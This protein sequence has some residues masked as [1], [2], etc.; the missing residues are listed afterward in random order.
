[1]TEMENNDVIYSYDDKLLIDNSG[2]KQTSYLMMSNVVNSLLAKQGLQKVRIATGYWDLNGWNLTINQIEKFLEN[3]ND[4]ECFQLLI[5]KDPMIYLNQ[6]QNEPGKIIKNYPKNEIKLDLEKLE[7]NEEYQRG[8]AV[9]LKYLKLGR[10]KVRR[11]NVVIDGKEQFLHSKCF[12]F[13][14]ANPVKWGRGIIGSSNFTKPGL[15][16][17]SEL[18]YLEDDY[19]KI[20]YRDDSTGIQ[21][22]GFVQWFEEKWEQ[23]EDWSKEFALILSDCPNGKIVTG[24]NPALSPE[25]NDDSFSDKL[26]PYE[27]YM[28]YL[29]MQIGDI[30]DESVTAQLTS[31]LPKNYD[32][33]EFQMDAVKQ[34]FYIMHNQRHNGCFLSDVVGLGKTVVAVLMI[35]KFIDEAETFGRDPHV[36]IVTP[37]AIKPGWI[38]TIKDFDK[39]SPNKIEPYISFI[40]TGSIGNLITEEGF[41]DSTNGE[42]TSDDFD[43]MPASPIYGMIVVDESHNFRN[44]T[45]NKYKALD[46]L[47][48]NIEI[49]KGWLPFVAL[50]SATPQNNSPVDLKNQICLFQRER[51]NSTLPVEGGKLEAFFNRCE[52]VYKDNRKISNTAEGKKAL[53][54]MAEE[55]RKCVLDSLVVRRTRTDIK[56]IYKEDYK[57]LRFPEVQPPVSLEYKMDEKLLNLY[58]RTIDSIWQEPR[59]DENGNLLPVED[60][61]NY[62]GFFRY[63]AISFIKD[64]EIKALYQKNNLTVSGISAR[65]QKIMQ[66]LLIKRLESSVDAFKE[67]LENLQKYTEN[68]MNMWNADTI[69]ICPDI[70]VNKEFEQ[71]SSF[72]D[73]IKNIRKKQQEKGGNNLELHK[74]HFESIYI[75]ALDATFSYSE[76]LAHDSIIINNLLKE[77]LKQYGNDPKLKAFEEIIDSEL[78]DPTKNNPSSGHKKLVIFTEAI[79]TQNALFEVINKNHPTLKVSSKDFNASNGKIT[80]DIIKRNFDAKCD[81]EEQENDFEV[82]I[83]TEVLAEGVNLHRSN[84]I[85]NYDAPWNATRLMQRIGRVNRIGSPEEKVYVY[86]FKPLPTSDK[87]INL[88]S[89]INSK[90]Q[91]FHTMF[92]EDNQ[93]YS[94]EE[95][96]SVANFNRTVNGESTPLAPYIRE[97]REYSTNNPERFDYIKQIELEE[98]G[99]RIKGRTETLA[100]VQSDRGTTLGV[101]ICNE[102]LNVI[103]PLPF[104]GKLKCSQDDVFEEVCKKEITKIKNNA[105]IAFNQFVSNLT[106]RRDDTPRLTKA[107]EI[108]SSLN[109]KVT[110]ESARTALKQINVAIRRNHN[111]Y[112]AGLLIKNKDMLLSEDLFGTDSKIEDVVMGI[113]AKLDNLSQPREGEK[114]LLF[115]FANE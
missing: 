32:P 49:E 52:K 88:V 91:A 4:E 74:E 15:Q 60:K 10:I 41:D 21:L 26:T 95:E 23:S 50:L 76:A 47:I 11:Y 31:Y 82:I 42:D 112:I 18:N 83:T 71:A 29:Y 81:E 99:G 111:D 19:Q 96:L 48:G 2:D 106:T 22:K 69:F 39:D 14:G 20:D 85:V 34:C 17:N 62:I 54:E 94:D 65:L 98:Q 33:I 3:T 51:N 108:I 109:E 107:K 12:I 67:S 63:S 105:I 79:A 7:V 28:K 66:I 80:R 38:D 110:S 43:E 70:D 25:P 44:S 84:M 56:D 64:E 61:E 27:L 59:Y 103:E 93:I 115:T 57:N 75:P 5:G 1:M 45:T 68:M 24:Q 97:L 92:G 104:M 77:W 40:T 35:K 36:L 86:N 58:S 9:L 100:L 46:E 53:K 72:E 89:I 16:N 13:T 8:I 102:E 37:P 78:F 90:L 30:T 101:S 55:I 6:L 113:G 87:Y 73:A 114:H